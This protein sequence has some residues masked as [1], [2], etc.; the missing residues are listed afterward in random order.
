M[1][2]GRESISTEKI[3]EGEIGVSIIGRNKGR[4]SREREANKDGFVYQLDFGV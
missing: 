3:G 2:K 4:V 1:V